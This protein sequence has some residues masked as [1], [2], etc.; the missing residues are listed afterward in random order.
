M[1]LLLDRLFLNKMLPSFIIYFQCL[2]ISSGLKTR[3]FLDLWAFGSLISVIKSTT[4]FN[5]ASLRNCCTNSTLDESD[6]ITS[7]AVKK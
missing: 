2:K 4:E 6:D 5:V 1:S 3:L 7:N